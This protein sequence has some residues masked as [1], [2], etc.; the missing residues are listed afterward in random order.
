M[1][2]VFTFFGYKAISSRIQENYNYLEEDV[3]II[4]KSYS[5]IVSKSIEASDVINSLLEE[6]II[7]AGKIGELYMG[8]ES[9]QLLIEIAE[10]LNVDEMYFYNEKG[11]L[12]YSSTYEDIGWVPDNNHPVMI[13]L[14]SDNKTFIEPIRK[15][16]FRELFMK[17]GYYRLENGTI[18]QIGVQAEKIQNFISSF[19]IQKILDSIYNEGIVDG[20]LFY[21]TNDTLQASTGITEVDS[22][23]YHEAK[24][25][26][27][28][29]EE[30]LGTL[31]IIKSADEFNI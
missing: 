15:D 12:I 30:I 19:E 22:K 25:F 24:A 4:A 23:F 7:S 20:I 27:G 29:G 16:T 11:K 18:Y 21:D 8:E 31:T 3:Y 2:F 6:K 1:F 9:N 28:K 13:F 5:E 26:V 10:R 14:N 17:F